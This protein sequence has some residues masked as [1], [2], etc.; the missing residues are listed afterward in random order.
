M[1]WGATGHAFC[2]TTT[3]EAGAL[4]DGCAGLFDED[5]CST[6]G[7]PLFWR[8]PCFSFSAN[9]AGSPRLNITGDELAEVTEW[10]FRT[11]QATQC[12][13]GLAPGFEAVR[14]PKAACDQSGF[15]PLGPNQNLLLFHDTAWPY[16]SAEKTIAVTWLTADRR[17]GEILDADIE[18]NSEMYTFTLSK[19]API[20]DL[21]SVVFHEA[22]HILGLSH[23]ARPESIMHQG[24]DKRVRITNTLSADDEAGICS[25]RV[26]HGPVEACDPEPPTGFSVACEV[27]AEGGGCQL[28]SPPRVGLG[29][30]LTVPF[31]AFVSWLRR[32]RVHPRPPGSQPKV[33]PS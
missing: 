7:F 16:P 30:V 12:A 6:E 33:P 15:R 25:L 23:S 19:T 17:T 4:T 18:L 29:T 14:F 2:R 26:A 3:C 13:D 8:S 5:G 31:L 22:G 9:E 11:W 10:S 27:H 24:Y 20:I 32:R 28:A 1:L 21:R